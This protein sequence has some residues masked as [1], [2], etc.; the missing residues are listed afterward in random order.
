MEGKKLEEEKE[1]H[2]LNMRENKKM[3]SKN[4]SEVKNFNSEERVTETK[5]T[6][7]RVLMKTVNKLRS[8]SSFNKCSV[9][10]INELYQEGKELGLIVEVAK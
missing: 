3:E 2:S 6:K 7:I 10:E 8:F 9:K 5:E 1:S 4:T